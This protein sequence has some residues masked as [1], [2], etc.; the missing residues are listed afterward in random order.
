MYHFKNTNE[1]MNKTRENVSY[2]QEY[3]QKRAN[4]GDTSMFKTVKHPRSTTRLILPHKISTFDPILTTFI[5]ETSDM[6]TDLTN[7]IVV[8]KEKIQKL[9]N[10]ISNN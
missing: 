1:W 2:K 8:L 4:N 10:Q 6:C 5:Y 7:T 9:E 3:I